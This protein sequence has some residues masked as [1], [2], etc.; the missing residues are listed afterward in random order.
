MTEPLKIALIR[1]KYNAAGGAERFVSRAIEALVGQGAEV[2]LLTRRWENVAGMQ[3]IKVAPFY[4]GNV[5]RDAGFAC[6]VRAELTKHDFDLVQSHERIA[7]CDVY[8]AGDGVHSEW[9]AR[10]RR[11]LSPLGRLSLALN[12]Y[13]HY[14]RR[15][16]RRM[17]LDP[18]LK[19]VI[20][21][22]EMVKQDILRHFPIDPAKLHVIYNGIDTER[23]HPR[24]REQLRADTRREL[25]IAP[26]KLTLLFVGSGYERKG[27][28]VLLT[29]LAD[30]GLDAD[31]IVVGKDKHA[32]R[33][34]AQAQR[35]GLSAR[36]HFLGAQNDPRPYYAA[37]DLFAFPTLYEPF[38]N[39]HLEAMA[40]GLPIITS[41]GAGA[42]ELV[43]PGENGYVCDPLD[44]TGLAEQLKRLS[45]QHCAE[46]GAQARLTAEGFRLDEMGARLIEFYRSLLSNENE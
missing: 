28:A 6:A 9:L 40:M 45:P 14:M 13:H 11:I 25:D 8:R 1:Q 39:V 3:P 7:G 4:L 31:L 42:A 37:A 32:A 36:V 23:F 17:F 26:D 12:P 21:I 35:L 16:E 41:S 34:Q 33:Y 43:R 24:L 10:R 22:S 46:M 29:A 27:L 5:W 38:G 15:A 18:A 2:T 19:A 44:S 30:S 20:C